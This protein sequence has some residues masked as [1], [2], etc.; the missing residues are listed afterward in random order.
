MNSTDVASTP[1]RR[2]KMWEIPFGFE[3][4]MLAYERKKGLDFMTSLYRDAFEISQPKGL[5]AGR[6]E[7]VMDGWLDGLDPG[8][9][10]GHR[11]GI[12]QGSRD[13]QISLILRV[14]KHRWGT[15]AP[16]LEARLSKLSL[17]QLE[18][19]GDM[20]LELPDPSA[21]QQWLGKNR[22]RS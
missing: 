22:K 20:I 10:Q 5:E 12:R 3:R 11:K 18:S 16:Q 1:K 15:L 13:G 19:W 9:K 4:E 14:L 2:K 7:G 21:L 8:R 6:D 17:T